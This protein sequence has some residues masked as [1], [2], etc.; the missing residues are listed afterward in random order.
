MKTFKTQIDI[1]KIAITVENKS[2]LR[3]IHLMQ[4]ILNNFILNINMLTKWKLSYWRS[5]KMH[6]VNHFLLFIQTNKN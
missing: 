6:H 2:F 4:N 5:K 1:N 3:W